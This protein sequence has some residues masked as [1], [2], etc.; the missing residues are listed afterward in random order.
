MKTMIEELKFS[1]ECKAETDVYQILSID[2]TPSNALPAKIINALI[3]GKEFHTIE[4][5]RIYIFEELKQRGF[6]VN[7]DNIQLGSHV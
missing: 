2:P 1:V 4:E 7:K 5:I 6:L 3:N